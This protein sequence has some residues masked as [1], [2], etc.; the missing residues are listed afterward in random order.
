M[1]TL[2]GNDHME[3]DTQTAGKLDNLKKQLEDLAG[4]EIDASREQLIQLNFAVGAQTY[5]NNGDVTSRSIIFP[6]KSCAIRRLLDASGSSTTEA[7]GKVTF[8]LSGFLCASVNSFAAPVNLVATPRAETPCYVTTS[9]SFVPNSSSPTDLQITLAAWH[10]NGT[11]A[12]KVGIDWRCRLV[13][14]Q[15]IG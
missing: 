13:S 12:P 6:N 3:L 1:E 5:D 7:N 15:I 14:I 4:R 9:Y 11:A 8:L 2:E 10:P